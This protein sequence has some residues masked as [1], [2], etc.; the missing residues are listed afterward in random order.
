M[1][2]YYLNSLHIP[3]ITAISAGLCAG[4][5]PIS[6][7]SARVMEEIGVN[8]AS[9]ISRQLT[10]ELAE[11]ADK[12]FCMTPSH[13]AVLLSCGIDGN[14]VSL[15]KEGGISD[16]FGGDTQ[17]YR[18]CRDEITEAVNSIFNITPLKVSYLN[19]QDIEK[20]AGLEE[21]CFG[22]PWSQ[23]A[24]NESMEGNN[25]FIG[26]KENGEL[27]GY[28]SFFLSFGEVYINNIATHPER[29]RQGVARALLRELMR[30]ANE[31][32]AEFLTLEVR[33]SNVPA[34]ELYTAFGFKEEG[35]RKNY[36]SAPKE[37]AIILT[38][39]F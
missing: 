32:G 3:D 23:R 36:Y 31:A 20:I 2:E 28:L 10:D 24:I 26:V 14:K 33:E 16:P 8:T 37:D 12:I 22:Q 7:N 19:S 15:L 11:K 27:I 35:R 39:R 4:Q 38:R 17:T 1:A 6:E 13:R 18:K 5:I 29:R 25:T 34:T 30:T 21:L 9:H